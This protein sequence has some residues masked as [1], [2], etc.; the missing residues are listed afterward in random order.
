MEAETEMIAEN[1]F[2]YDDFYPQYAN[3]VRGNLITVDHDYPI[4]YQLSNMLT[5]NVTHICHM[6]L[7]SIFTSLNN[8]QSLEVVNRV[9]ESQVQMMEIFSTCQLMD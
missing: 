5:E 8:C 9:S 4:K 1:Y 3:V 6:S 2:S 7:T